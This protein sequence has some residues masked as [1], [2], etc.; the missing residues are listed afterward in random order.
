MRPLDTHIPAPAR[1]APQPHWPAGRYG[2]RR[3]GSA[4]HANYEPS[5]PG[6]F[7]PPPPP[8]P[9]LRPF[10]RRLLPA[11]NVI[12]RRRHRRIPRVPRGQPLQPANPILQLGDH[13]SQFPDNGEQLGPR[14]LLESR[15][16]QDHHRNDHYARTREPPAC[17]TTYIKIN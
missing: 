10:R 9:A 14:Q 17:R 5:A 15:H 13:A 7:P 12:N 16:T 2:I 1:S 4:T 3:S 11:R 8:R 6:R